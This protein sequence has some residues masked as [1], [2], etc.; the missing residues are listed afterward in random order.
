MGAV[1]DWGLFW[2]FMGVWALV[3]V[4]VL[5][6]G[7]WLR[8]RIIRAMRGRNVWRQADAMTRGAAAQRAREKGL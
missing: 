6:G 7:W 2:R 4:V 8:G 5:A 1:V 3:F